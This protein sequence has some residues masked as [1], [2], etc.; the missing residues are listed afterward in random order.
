MKD[1]INVGV[2]GMLQKDLEIAEFINKVNFNDSIMVKHKYDFIE[3]I[4]EK[5]KNL[6]IKII[7]LISYINELDNVREY[8]LLKNKIFEEN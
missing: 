8:I 3:R 1:D 6:N 4:S 5:K 7:R 2:N